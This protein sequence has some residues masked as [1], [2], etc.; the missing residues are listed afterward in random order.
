MK[1]KNIPL[2]GRWIVLAVLLLVTSLCRALPAWGFAYHLNVYPVIARVLSHMSCLLPFAIGDVFIA[3]SIAGV[4]VWPWYAVKRRGTTWRRALLQDAEYLAWVYVW[5]YAAWGLNYSQPSIWARMGLQPAEADARTFRQFAA[6]Y[7]DSL[8]AAWLRIDSVDF[9]RL[10]SDVVSGYRQMAADPANGINAPFCDSAD[11][12]RMVFSPLSSMVGVTGSMGPFFCEF[13]LNADLLPHSYPATY[14]HEYSHFLGVANEGE[15]N[16][17]AY[18][19][20]TASANPQMRFSGYYSVFFHMLGN[21]YTLLGEKETEAWLARIRPEI[22]RQARHDRQ[23]W[24]DK[25][26][27]VL[28]TLQDWAYDFYLR[29]NHVEGGRKSYSGVVALIMAWQQ[30]H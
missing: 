26:S 17:Y 25:H 18:L 29:S 6:N 4:V 20:C 1:I 7:A 19:V 8:N 14:A 13:T 2:R 24:R 27:R 22:R 23:Y 9:D 28:G 10:H 15:A 16:F 5:F 11:A 21:V 3:L 30:K 12:K